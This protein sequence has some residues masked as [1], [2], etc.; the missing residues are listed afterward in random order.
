MTQKRR[1]YSSDPIKWGEIIEKAY[2]A[3]TAVVSAVAPSG[4]KNRQQ[5]VI[6]FHGDQERILIVLGATCQALAD[7]SGTELAD[8]LADLAVK[9]KE[10]KDAQIREEEKHIIR[11][12]TKSGLQEVAGT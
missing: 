3:E 7:Q 2:Y 8:L 9:A 1:I 5:A 10:Y 12:Q 6:S 4:I 11:R